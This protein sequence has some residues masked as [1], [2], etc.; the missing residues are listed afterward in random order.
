MD[1]IWLELQKNY[2][3]MK[4]FK[5]LKGWQYSMLILSPKLCGKVL[6]DLRMPKI[7]LIIILD[8][9]IYV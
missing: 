8:K 2:Y 4:V 5:E 6:H 3:R 1:I 7:L 9:I